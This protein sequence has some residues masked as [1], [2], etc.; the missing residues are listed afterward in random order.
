M[1]KDTQ[2]SPAPISAACEIVSSVGTTLSTN[3]TLSATATII[4]KNGAGGN[5]DHVNWRVDGNSLGTNSGPGSTRTGLTTNTSHI[6]KAQ[7][8]FTVW[9]GPANL[10]L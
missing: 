10:H 6:Y 5:Y 8:L 4:L 3:N 9:A 1:L 7:Y 2:L